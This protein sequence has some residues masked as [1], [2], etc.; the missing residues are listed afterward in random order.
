MISLDLLNTGYNISRC[1]R[2]LVRISSTKNNYHRA[3]DISSNLSYKKKKFK[4]ELSKE[5]GC[6]GNKCNLRGNKRLKMRWSRG[7]EMMKSTQ[8]QQIRIFCLWVWVK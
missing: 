5:H 6:C 8:V 1:I 3:N 7:G 4:V 2:N